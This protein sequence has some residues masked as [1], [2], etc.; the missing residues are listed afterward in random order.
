MSLD[1][2]M[3]NPMEYGQWAAWLADFTPVAETAK[4]VC[5]IRELDPGKTIYFF[6]IFMFQ[7]QAI[8]LEAVLMEAIARKEHSQ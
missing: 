1:T 2:P 3:N 7:W 8:V 4:G 5:A 6:G